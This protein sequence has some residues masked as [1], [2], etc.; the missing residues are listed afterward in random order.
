MQTSCVQFSELHHTQ[1]VCIAVTNV[2]FSDKCSNTR[3]CET[4][5]IARTS[6]GIKHVQLWPH[7]G[8]TLV[9][10]CI[11]LVL[12]SAP[13][14]ASVII[15]WVLCVLLASRRCTISTSKSIHT[16]RHTRSECVHACARRNQPSTLM[17]MHACASPESALWCARAHAFVLPY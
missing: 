10:W 9:A 15:I 11:H 5:I 4:A 16:S 14:C 3:E 1:H 17:S 6:G 2:R 13:M 7:R 12:Q 8:T